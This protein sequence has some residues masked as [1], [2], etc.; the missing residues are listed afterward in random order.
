MKRAQL[1]ALAALLLPLMAAP[2][3]SG[4]V[5]QPHPPKGKGVQCVAE[6]PFMRRNHPDL[7]K[8]QRDDTLRLGIRGEKYSLKD[9]IACHAVPGKT[10]KPV[11]YREPE[12]FCKS[13]HTYAAVTID[14][15]E[16]HASTPEADRRA[17]VAPVFAH[18]GIAGC[19]GG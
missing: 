19:A 18:A 8:H 7:L 15:F 2:V 3:W 1:I 17:D 16:C 10:G 6:T 9:C 11:T 4:S 5:P 14:C 13:C 12:H